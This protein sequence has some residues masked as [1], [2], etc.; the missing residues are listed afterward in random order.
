MPG[1]LTRPRAALLA[2]LFA[3]VG[4][5]VGL[6]WWLTPARPRITWPT[7]SST[8]R[9]LFF[10]HD[11]QTILT[12]KVDRLELYDVATGHLKAMIPNF[13][14]E[15]PPGEQVMVSPGGRM[16]AV[17]DNYSRPRRVQLWVP[18]RA[19][20]PLP[21]GESADVIGFTPDGATLVTYGAGR[22]MLWDTATLRERPQPL[23]IEDTVA[24]L[25]VLP[26]GRIVALETITE[27]GWLA[28]HGWLKV[29]DVGAGKEGALLPAEFGLVVI[30]PDGRLAAARA[31]HALRVFDLATGQRVGLIPLSG[32]EHELPLPQFSADSRRLLIHDQRADDSVAEL[33]DVSTTPPRKLHAV[34]HNPVALG[35]D[36][37]LAVC[38][39]THNT[40]DEAT[41]LLDAET[42]QRRGRCEGCMMVT[43]AADG[44]TCAGMTFEQHHRGLLLSWLLGKPRQDE[45]P[46]PTGRVWT[47][48]DGGT[49]LATAIDEH[50]AF[51]PDG[52]SIVF[53]K[54]DGGLEVWDI[55]PHRPWY[56]NAALAT[57]LATFTAL[58]CWFTFQAVRVDGALTEGAP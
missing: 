46:R 45:M 20:F 23:T 50:Y 13:W 32:H 26:D 2:I 1:K 41:D 22:Y 40:L 35:P 11:G 39:L 19:E 48:P 52:K 8:W 9:Q 21:L 49:V 31:L 6:L 57:L 55:P 47:V 44:R 18:E 58:S 15:A 43:F 5:V 30:A 25:R 54:D 36:G 7:D 33:W 10:S 4:V 38:D 17:R 56:V 28:D 16:V 29:W 42:M 37:T 53:A 12:A 14:D 34:V 3:G 24:A 27:P 51:A